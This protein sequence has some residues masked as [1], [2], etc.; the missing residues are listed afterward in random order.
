MKKIVL[1][2]SLAG[3]LSC[4]MHVRPDYPVTAKV[5]TVDTYF[6][7][8]VPD[9][10]RWLE[11]DT[12]PETEAWVVEQNKVTFAY[13]EKIPFR[14][15]L[16]QRITELWNYPRYSSPFKE[17]EHYFYFKNNGLQNQ[18]VLYIQ[19]SLGGES[20]ILLDPNT[21]SEDGTVALADISPSKD[22]KYL[23]Y[24]IA[25]SG[26]DWNEIFFRDIATGKDLP[27]HIE[28]VKFSGLSWYNDGI[29]YSAYDKPKKG[30]ELSA[31][32]KYHK[33]YYHKI[34][35]LQKDDKLI[36]S[37]PQHALRN[38]GAGTTEDQKYLILSASE[39][40]SGNSL[41]IKSTS[42]PDSKFITIYE[43]FD[44]DYSVIDNFDDQIIIITNHDAPRYKLIKFDLKTG[45]RT[46]LVPQ[47]EN[48][49]RG[50][51]VAADKLVLSYM[52]D[53]RS[54]IQIHNFDGTFDYNLDLP[55]IGTCGG[56]SGKKN[57]PVAFYTFTSYTIPPVIY[58]YNFD[59]KKSE[60][61]IKTE[62]PFNIDDY[63]T[64]QV[65]YTS[66]DGTKIPM[67][68]FYKKGMERNGKNPTLLYG[69]GGFNV[70]L[71]PAFTPRRMVWLENGG[72]FAVANL[73]GGGEYGEDW[74]QAGTK[75]NKQNVF[76]DCIAAAEYLI[77]NKYTCSK[78]LALKGGSNGGL[79]VGAVINQRP[80]LFRVA[81]PMVGVMDMLRYHKFTI[82]WAWA[83]D[84][85]TSDDSIQ[86]KNLLSYSPVHTI[87]ENVEYPAVLVT[88]A[89]H[90]DRVVPAHSFKY[91]ATLQEKYKGKNPVMIRI[92]SKAGHGGGM[93]TSKQIEEFADVW[94]FIFYNMGINPY[95]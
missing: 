83:G 88:T 67:F 16:K 78:F 69:Y 31:A 6:G 22:G 11:N 28:W 29:Y 47:T 95:K 65:F 75:L 14:E 7:T 92:E 38:Y 45:K 17:G 50:A 3:L 46:D 24:S 81:I 74:H 89:D 56:L 85:G 39:G 4:N 20:R 2:A 9:P 41:M 72:I 62:V 70:S 58:K 13:L 52:K 53:A 40:T 21:L 10:Y 68:L 59:Q 79:L 23:A 5:D 36:Y 66:K 30:E 90:D 63:I 71:T 51:S 26:S 19:D 87:K 43:G 12:S 44:F 48:V 8:K 25:R 84:Y 33:V 1:M 34:G 82:G 60:I 37:D 49:L 32:N 42:Q 35:T 61:Y 18:S 93:P 80:D 86:F 54:L 27:D 94:S 76:D 64:E 77:E 55:G 57:D 73:R 91:I 15:K